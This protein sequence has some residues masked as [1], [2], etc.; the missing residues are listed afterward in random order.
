MKSQ[1]NLLSKSFKQLNL[2]QTHKKSVHFFTKNIIDDSP[3]DILKLQ[4]RLPYI[5]QTMHVFLDLGKNR[6][7]NILTM[8]NTYFN[9]FNINI[10][11]NFKVYCLCALLYV[12]LMKHIHPSKC[13][14][15]T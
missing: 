14:A 7:N 2:L 13:W 12:S 3:S 6:Y 9:I 1:D 15:V 4:N 10:I 8:I 11:Y 5:S